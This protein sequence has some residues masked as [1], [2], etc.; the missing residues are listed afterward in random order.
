MI[1]RPPRSTLFPYTT[2]FRSLAGLRVA[3]PGLGMFPEHP[4]GGPF[5]LADLAAEPG[6]LPVSAPERRAVAFLGCGQAEQEHVH[7]AVGRSGAHRPGP[8]G[9]GLPR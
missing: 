7:A 3:V 6:D 9:G 8:P 2:L 5:A 4:Q 1:R